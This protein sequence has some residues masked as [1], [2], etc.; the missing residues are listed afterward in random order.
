MEEYN[1]WREQERG[2]E[3]YNSREREGGHVE[4]ERA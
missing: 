1:D 4:K 2:L 3:E